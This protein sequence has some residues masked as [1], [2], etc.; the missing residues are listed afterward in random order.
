MM[1]IIVTD[2]HNMEH[3]LWSIFGG[4]SEK[5]NTRFQEHNVSTPTDVL[6]S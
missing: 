4:N 6:I 2:E 3:K 5:H 1:S